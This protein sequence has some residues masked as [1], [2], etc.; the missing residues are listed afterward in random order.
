MIK[1][2]IKNF[3]FEEEKDGYAT[4]YTENYLRLY[5]KEYNGNKDF[6]KVKILQPFLD[7]ALATVVE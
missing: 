2:K 1:S 7:G 5:I 3:L 4:G 6:Q